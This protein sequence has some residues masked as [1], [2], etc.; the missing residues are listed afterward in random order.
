M[1]CHRIR[2]IL[3]GTTGPV[4]RGR[5]VKSP[6]LDPN[7]TYVIGGKASLNATS[8]EPAGYEPNNEHEN[9]EP[10]N[11]NLNQSVEVGRIL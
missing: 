3:V 1:R 8:S 10:D 9:D 4:I 11:E 7:S 2:C 5:A 6:G